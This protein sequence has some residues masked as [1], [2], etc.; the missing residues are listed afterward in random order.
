MNKFEI[1]RILSA[2]FFLFIFP[3]IYLWTGITAISSEDKIIKIAGVLMFIMVLQI[4]TRQKKML[5]T[6]FVVI[7][8]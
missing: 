8:I 6:G 4:I 3:A 7:F 1:T 2:I 5:L